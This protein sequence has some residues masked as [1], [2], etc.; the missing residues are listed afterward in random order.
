MPL[1]LAARLWKPA[2]L[3]LLLAGVFVYRAVLVHQ[4]DSA[5]KQVTALSLEAAELQASNSKL[6]SAI[7]DQNSALEQ[8]HQQMAAAQQAAAQNQAD[9]VR[10]AAA[11]MQKY[12]MSAK[13]LNQAPVPAG[14]EGAIEWGNAQGPE[15]GQW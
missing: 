9:N 3:G 11:I 6:E 5:R 2:V 12:E 7:N 15:L 1:L 8:M 10:Q 13:A 14:C 4:R